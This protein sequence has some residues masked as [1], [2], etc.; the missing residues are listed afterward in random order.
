MRGTVNLQLASDHL[1]AFIGLVDEFVPVYERRYGIGWNDDGDP[2]L[3]GSL[4]ELDDRVRSA[5]PLVREIAN[6]LEPSLAQEFSE[7]PQGVQHHWT[8]ARKAAVELRGAVKA[9]A[10]IAEVIGPVGPQLGAHS[11]HP[12]VWSAAAKLWDDGHHS[13]AIQ[14]AASAVEGQ[15]QAKLD[16]PDIAGSDLAAAFSVKSATSNLPRL[17]LPGF[18]PGSKTHT[19]AHEGTSALIRGT[20]LAIRNNASHPGGPNPTPEEAL[21]QL[22]TLSF[23]ARL[24]DRAQVS[25]TD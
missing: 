13:Q 18:Q 3:Q 17:R 14:A 5:L 7:W 23:L 6:A 12:L 4:D 11:L 2:R 8:R 25:S 10:A 20:M 9:Q 15:L 22:A 1:A 16:R 21:E 19:S 24:I